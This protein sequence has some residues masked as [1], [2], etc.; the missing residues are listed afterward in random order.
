MISWPV[1]SIRTPLAADLHLQQHASTA[2]MLAGCEAGDLS[3]V[4]DTMSIWSAQL[5][6]QVHGS[7]LDARDPCKIS[8]QVMMS[9]LGH[10]PGK[11]HAPDGQAL[12]GAPGCLEIGSLP[13]LQSGDILVMAGIADSLVGQ[14]GEAW[15]ADSE[16]QAWGNPSQAA[17]I[18]CHDRLVDQA[19]SLHA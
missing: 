16:L 6:A 3:D 18:G 1:E 11:A 8:R 5:P 15:A 9:V 2:C 10:V 19:L 14:A 7:G 17:L 4:T 13:G 12:V